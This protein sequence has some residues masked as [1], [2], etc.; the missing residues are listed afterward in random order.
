[1]K[2]V[3]EVCRKLGHP[4]VFNLLGPLTNPASVPYQVLGVGRTFLRPL[5]AEAL[6]LLGTTRSAIV[7]GCGELDEVSLL[8]ET[9]AT[10]VGPDGVE[11]VIWK[12]E[13]FG[14]EPISCEALRV[15]GPG[16]SAARIKEML[17]GTP[18]PIMDT[19]LANSAVGLWLVGRVN[20]LSEGV[21]L[22]RETILSGKA[23]DLLAK[24]AERSHR[25]T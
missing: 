21:A 11:E 19:V 20:S 3:A 14:L 18:G 1:M 12:P 7:Y 25:S 5:L 9:Q 23:R 15:S 2:N 16:E 6:Q 4:T 22:A 24:W 10:I 13:D 8:G 17:D